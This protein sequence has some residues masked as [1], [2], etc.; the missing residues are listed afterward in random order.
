MQDLKSLI[1]QHEEWLTDRVI[2]YAQQKD[3]TQFSSTLREAW[4][5][6]VCGLSKPL[7]EFLDAAQDASVPH[8]AAIKAATDFG[9]T[10]GV[11]HRARGIELGGDFVGLMK[12]YRNAY[13][14]LIHDKADTVDQ[15]RTLQGGLVI[16]LFDSIEV[17]LLVSWGGTTKTS[18]QLLEL[19]ARNRALTNEK[20]KYLT[21]FESIAEPAILLGPNREPTHVNAAAN[22][23]LLGENEPVPDIMVIWTAPPS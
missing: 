6:S 14:D 16:E 7:T 13:L 9:V 8:K 2:H 23:L 5:M 19:Q 15:A 1:E 4:R 22:R 21:V 10:Q 20:N 17:G 18:D 12:L 11:Q 3:F